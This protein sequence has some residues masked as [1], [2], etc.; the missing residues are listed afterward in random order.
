MNIE[1]KQDNIES[2]S[3]KISKI[4]KKLS[5]DVVI[6]ILL[7]TG[8]ITQKNNKLRFII[9]EYDDRYEMLHDLYTFIQEN[10]KDDHG[11][12]RHRKEGNFDR[13]SISIP[14]YGKNEELRFFQ[15]QKLL[16]YENNFKIMKWG[17]IRTLTKDN[18]RDYDSS[19]IESVLYFNSDREFDSFSSDDDIDTFNCI[20]IP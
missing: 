5:R 16:F 6:H 7:F 2:N 13:I 8:R 4:F 3:K 17:E 19:D 14:F 20:R 10:R 15:Y 12:F 18:P 11:S 1:Q 9:S